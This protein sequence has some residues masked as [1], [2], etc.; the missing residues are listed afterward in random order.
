[1]QDASASRVRPRK[2]MVL[3]VAATLIGI[4]ST[5]L[6]F[7]AQHPT[8]P[9]QVPAWVILASLTAIAGSCVAFPSTIDRQQFPTL[10]ESEPLQDVMVYGTL[11]LAPCLVAATIWSRENFHANHA[12]TNPIST[13][14]ACIW[15]LGI[16]AAVAAIWSSSPARRRTPALRGWWHRSPVG[17]AEALVLFA[18]L[19]VAVGLRVWHL[20]SLPEGVWIDEADNATGA[21]RL[22]HMPFQ[23]IQPTNFNTLPPLYPYVMTFFFWIGGNTLTDVR[24]TS[25]FF[26]VLTVLG[27]YL[28][29]RW[30]GDPSLGLCAALLTAVAQ[31]AVDFSRF[32]VAQDAAPGS[33]SL[34]LAAFCVA[35]LRPRSLWFAVAGILLGFSLLSY[36]GAFSVATVGTFG[37]LA[38]RLI[39]DGT[40]RRKAWPVVLLLPVGMLVGAAPLLTAIGLD[41][42]YALGRLNQTSLFS[43]Y[44]DWGHRLSGLG[45]NLRAHLLMFTIAGDGNGRHNLPGVPMVDAVTGT[46]FLLGLGMCLRRCYQ[47]FYQLLLFWL[48]LALLGGILSLDFEA[49]QASRVIAAI[50][51]V[52]LISALPLALLARATWVLVLLVLVWLAR[53][54]KR[55]SLAANGTAPARPLAARP[56]A[57]ALAAAVTAVPL[58]MASA[59]NV[60]GYFNQHMG[61]LSSW[62]DMGGDLGIM[63]RAVPP[64][65]RQGYAVFVDPIVAG[66]PGLMYAAGNR[67][68]PAYDISVPVQLPLPRGG[69]ALIIPFTNPDTLAS[70]RS[71][72]P[73]ARLTTLTPS[74]DHSVVRATVLLVTAEDV[75]RNTGLTTG[76]SGVA[77]SVVSP[78]QGSVVSWPPG[79][80]AVVRAS[81]RGA[82]MIATQQGGLPIALRLLGTGHATI[83]LDGVDLPTA[84]GAGTSTVH[85]GA[86]NHALL[87]AA[88]GATLPILRLQ[89]KIGRIWQDIPTAALASPL[90]PTGGLLGRYYSGAPAQGSPALWRVDPTVNVYYQEPPQGTNWPFSIQW[91]GTITAAVAGSYTFDIDSVGAAQ[92]SLDNRPLFSDPALQSKKIVIFLSAGRHAIRIDYSTPGGGGKHV[93]VRWIPPG[94]ALVPIPPSVLDPADP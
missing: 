9:D 40:Y 64:L 39:T 62:S 54:S 69:V 90:V 48:L 26:G 30:A 11:L 8:L 79:S 1:M 18:V 32:G 75:A 78:H 28:I 68:P 35:M 60:D 15:L 87:A 80:G 92:V 94:G 86:G 81:I 61:D 76:F 29:G 4:A 57:V 19:V 50:P 6:A 46:C 84:G 41:S 67:N 5:A 74:F 71:M 23:P 55:P 66:T 16:I 37:V 21:S 36:Y 65:L 85:L 93:Y 44:P 58:G 70:A 83:R 63:G 59:R 24:L 45:A 53:R 91:S 2:A 27:V 20:G 49:P 12:F 89:W 51:P 82:L 17:R 22:L 42:G 3:R 38:L 7:L 25:A 72:Y 56:L 43:E 33:L 77:R 34:A 13:V 31:W 88:Y 47:W 52:M 73:L 10:R 14:A